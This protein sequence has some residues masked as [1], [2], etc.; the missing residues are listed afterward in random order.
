MFVNFVAPTCRS[1]LRSRSLTN[2]EERFCL[3]WSIILECPVGDVVELSEIA[4]AGNRSNR[5]KS[6]VKTP[7]AYPASRVPRELEHLSLSYTVSSDLRPR[8]PVAI[9]DD[10]TQDSVFVKLMHGKSASERNAFFSMLKK[11][12]ASHKLITADYIKH[13]ET[14]GVS[15]DNDDAREVR[16]SSYMAL[17]NK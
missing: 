16:K 11:D 9:M 7:I 1:L 14:N 12:A 4:Y 3:L 13:W 5:I 6:G 2:N 8:L 15:A 10:D 17:V